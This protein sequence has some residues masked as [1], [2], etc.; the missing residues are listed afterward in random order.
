VTSAVGVFGRG[1]ELARL[2]RFLDG[3]QTRSGALVLRGEMGIGKSALVGAAMA[4]AGALGFVVLAAAPDAPEVSLPF[5]ALV[6]LL[7]P[8]VDAASDLLPEPQLQALRAVLLRDPAGLGPVEPLVIGVAM[9]GLARS[10][11]RRSP[12]LIAIDDAQ[13]LD[14]SSEAALRFVARRLR[15]EP[16]GILLAV[17]PVTGREPVPVLAGRAGTPEVIDLEAIGDEALVELLRARAG[18][19]LSARQMR[20]V[21]ETAGGN[22]FFA[23]ELRASVARLRGGSGQPLLSIPDSLADVLERRLAACPP[24]VREALT[25]TAFLAQPTVAQVERALDRKASSWLGPSLAEGILLRRGDRLRFAHPLL[26]SAAA[27]QISGGQAALVHRRLA[28]LVDDP[29]ERAWHLAAGDGGPDVTEA[30]RIAAGAAQAERRGGP[31]E[32]AELYLAAAAR[33]PDRSR[34][35]RTDWLRAAARCFASSGATGRARDLLGELASTMDAGPERADVLL[36]LG[37]LRYRADEPEEALGVLEQ[38]LDEARPAPATAAAIERQLAL[39]CTLKGDLAAAA[40][41]A[42]RAIDLAEWSGE[43]AALAG[44]LA[45][46]AMIDF[47]RGRGIDQERI[48]RAVVLESPSIREPVEWRPSTIEA[49]ILWWSGRPVEASARLERLHARALESGDEDAIPYL[50]YMRAQVELLTGNWELAQA[51]AEVGRAYLAETG[52]LLRVLLG[53]SVAQV[54]AALGAAASARALA[55]AGL[56]L[57][58]S[59]GYGPGIQ[60]NAGV[61]GSLALAEGDPQATIDVL[62]PM[63]PFLAQVGLG[64]PGVLRFVPD[65]VE[66]YTAVGRLDEADRCLQPYLADARRLGRTSALAAAT[67]CH[68]LIC[69][70]R[71]DLDVALDEAKRAVAMQAKLSIPFEQAR[72][73]LALGLVHRRRQEKRAAV[74]AFDESLELLLR[75]GAPAWI[76]R[77]RDERRRVGLRP[78]A[79]ETLSATELRVAELAAQG[80]TAREVGAVAF[81]SPKGVE[82]ALAR[83]YRKLEIGS[84]AELGRW[85]AERSVDESEGGKAPLP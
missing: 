40:G 26:R 61:L 39:T 14:P 15:Q 85:M 44:G 12:V 48:G 17:R 46:T 25:V 16:V 65:L 77:I 76:A 38:A 36:H 73:L 81:L 22:P 84:R 13:W 30:G 7:D 74:A 58:R 54:D 79:P 83:V 71:G 34:G 19:P 1:G 67:R 2:R 53:A 51:L 8:I 72:A 55:T 68:A 41:H 24:H 59:R 20:Q 70:A 31:G 37:A 43:D 49:L 82:K 18:P 5:A 50:L 78:R 66:A 6:D 4:M 28:A 33:L 63:V 56:E 23:L 64:E 69:L 80:L 3:L 62:S 32:A 75:L 52:A 29:I 45:F 35:R 21:V 10:L 60:E 27:Q 57:A 42:A 47:L 11:A 9:L